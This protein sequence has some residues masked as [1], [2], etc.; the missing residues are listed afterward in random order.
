MSLDRFIT[1]L[2]SKTNNFTEV[3]TEMRFLNVIF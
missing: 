1:Y 2:R 3:E